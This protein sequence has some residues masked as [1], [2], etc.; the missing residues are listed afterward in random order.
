MKE[1]VSGGPT[2]ASTFPEADAGL[3]DIGD[4]PKESPLESWSSFLRSRSETAGSETGTQLGVKR[5][6]S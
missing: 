3:P 2:R 6:L 1:V 4:P 5:A